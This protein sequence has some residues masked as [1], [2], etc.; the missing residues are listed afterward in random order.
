MMSFSNETETN[1]AKP[2]Q[3]GATGSVCSV[4][5]KELSNRAL[6]QSPGNLAGVNGNKTMAVVQRGHTR[7]PGFEEA[8]ALTR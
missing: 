4:S 2:S 8:L 7:G 5:Y 6:S 3:N 1:R